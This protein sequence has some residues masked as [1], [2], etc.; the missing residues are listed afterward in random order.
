MNRK[1]TVEVKFQL[2]LVVDEGT[3]IS[4]VMD[5]M[6]CTFLDQTGKANVVD[7]A[8]LDYEVTDSK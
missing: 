7:S 4:S 3:E 5:E 6:D 2:Q 1:V 8:M